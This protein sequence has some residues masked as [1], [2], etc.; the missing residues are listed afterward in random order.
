[1]KSLLLL[2]FIPLAL[3]CKSPEPMADVINPHGVDLT[4]VSVEGEVAYSSSSNLQQR[5]DIYSP[6]EAP[7]TLPPLLVFVHGGAW[8]TGDKSDY[9]SLGKTFAEQGIVTAVLNYR[10][11]PLIRH[12]G[13]AEDLAAALAQ[14]AND[15]KG[16]DP[17]RIYVMGHSAGAHMCAYLAAN[18]S[19][20]LKAG[21]KQEDFPKGF[22]GLEGIYDVPNLVQKWPKY[23]DQFVTNAFGPEQSFWAQSSPTREKIQLK[24][25]WLLVQSTADELV[26]KAQSDDFLA[27]L[28]KEGVEATLFVPGPKL[29]HFGVVT[30]LVN[31]NNELF[32][33]V[34]GLV[35]K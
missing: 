15:A 5:Y 25:K 23:K 16:F 2:A 21:M 22:I 9:V 29:S 8:Q 27:H 6:A 26:D 1:M 18:P 3:S 30:D 17:K 7:K 28:K 14:L 20:L 11:A 4:G 13:H 12:P 34:V 33:A 35:Q 32:K 24:S 19:L 10:L 31:T